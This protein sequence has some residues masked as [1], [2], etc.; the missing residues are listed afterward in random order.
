MQVQ[1]N[2]YLRSRF[3]SAIAKG[4]GVARIQLGVFT[5]APFPYSAHFPSSPKGPFLFCI[6]F[7]Y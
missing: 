4:S 3:R 6:S 1:V 7:E 2:D 5:P